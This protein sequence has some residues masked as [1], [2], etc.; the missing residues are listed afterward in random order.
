MRTRIALVVISVISC[1][2]SDKSESSRLVQHA[3]ELSDIRTSDAAPFRLRARV[4]RGGQPTTDAVYLLIWVSAEQWREEISV[5]DH[6]SIRIGGKGTVSSMEENQQ[7]QP[8]LAGP[9]ILNLPT[10]LPVTEPTA[11]SGVRTRH[12]DG[13][14][15]KCISHKG[16]LISEIEYC[17]N[18]DTGTLASENYLGEV[19]R[20]KTVEF[21]DYS[22]FR[23]K[24]FPRVV[25]TSKNSV[26]EQEITVVELV[27]DPSHDASLFAV[28]SK[29]KTVAGCEY[30][31]GPVPIK[32]PDP[33]YPAAFRSFASQ[34]VK[35]KGTIDERGRIQDISVT[36]SAGALD[37][38][39]VKAVSQWQFA[40]A[41]CGTTAVPH[42]FSTEVHFNMR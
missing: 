31:T 8:P 26:V 35:V 21:L 1:L 15:V 20:G 3:I 19:D 24:L 25:R 28:N 27:Y 30:P 5:G 7:G 6:K 2:A 42:P 34:T 32:L 10:V 29:Y 36:Q 40:P 38:Y 16:K 41:R 14:E 39:A 9:R 37:Q 11:L 18:S 12:Q 4:R 17:F 23:G 22:E 33:E 13:H